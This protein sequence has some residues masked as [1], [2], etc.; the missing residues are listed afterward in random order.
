MK[1]YGERI[2]RTKKESDVSRRQK[3]EN[4]LLQC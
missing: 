4:E 2:V 1:E 3:E